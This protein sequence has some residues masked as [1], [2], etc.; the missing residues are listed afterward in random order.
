MVDFNQ[1][2]MYHNYKAHTTPPPGF[3]GNGTTFCRD[4]PS[5]P[6]RLPEELEDLPLDLEVNRRSESLYIETKRQCHPVLFG[7]GGN[8]FE[9]WG[10]VGCMWKNG[11]VSRCILTLTSVYMMSMK[12]PSTMMKSNTFQASPK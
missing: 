5:R 6:K 9:V 11:L 12:L 8:M 4:R 10:L 1:L 2:R 7:L 3:H